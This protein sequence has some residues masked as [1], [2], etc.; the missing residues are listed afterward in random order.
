MA[1][2]L[3]RIPT[4]LLF[5]IIADLD[6]PGL[7]HLR[8]TCRTFASIIPPQQWDYEVLASADDSL[9][10]VKHNRLTCA[11][12]ERMRPATFFTDKQKIQTAGYRTCID[13]L[14]PSDDVFY[15][16][17][18]AVPKNAHR[19]CFSRERKLYVDERKNNICQYCHNAFPR[20]GCRDA[21]RAVCCGCFNEEWDAT[22]KRIAE[23]LTVE[24][25][26]KRIGP[27]LYCGQASEYSLQD[28]RTLR[29]YY[30]DYLGWIASSYCSCCLPDD[31]IPAWREGWRGVTITKART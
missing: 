24:N 16:L 17:D 2:P 30:P 25:S 6:F 9:W 3:F 21:M 26:L 31:E 10:A 19:T 1:S 8:A 29:S 13:C 23:V 27:G 14:L 15:N 4:E 28:L 12:C 11:W 22:D 5:L 7:T 20:W 18:Y